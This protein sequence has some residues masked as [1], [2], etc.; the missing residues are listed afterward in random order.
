[1]GITDKGRKMDR[2]KLD[3]LIA[4]HRP[5][6]NPDELAWLIENVEKTNPKVIIEI[7]VERGGT[8]AIWERILP[9][10]GRLIGLDIQNV[11]A[12]LDVSKSDRKV[13]LLTLNSH[14]AAT[15]QAMEQALNGERADFMYVD[16]D[17]GYAGVKQDFT[18]YSPLVRSGGLVGFHDTSAEINNVGR[19]FAELRAQYPNDCDER[20]GYGQGCGIWWKR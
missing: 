7:G 4:K 11:Q 1:M 5:V 16:G 18:W 9:P 2:A 13:T 17:H 3:E 15:F 6:Q 12:E 14:E 10:G 19:F 20:K 8:F